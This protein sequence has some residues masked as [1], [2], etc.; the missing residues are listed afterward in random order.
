VVHLLQQH[1]FFSDLAFQGLV[2]CAQLSG[3]LGHLAL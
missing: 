1:F 3:A 2:G